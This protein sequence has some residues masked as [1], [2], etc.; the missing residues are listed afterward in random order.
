MKTAS[1][2]KGKLQDF[3]PTGGFGA[4]KSGIAA[5]SGMDALTG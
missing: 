3:S 2:S 1:F 5:F 4:E